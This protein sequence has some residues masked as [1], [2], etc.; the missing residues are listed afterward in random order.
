MKS[1]YPSKGI[2]KFKY[3]IEEYYETVKKDE[4]DLFADR[5]ECLKILCDKT[6]FKIVCT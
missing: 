5:E 6:S 1:K 4:I 3:S 2:R